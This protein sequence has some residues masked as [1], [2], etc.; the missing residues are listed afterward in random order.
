MVRAKRGA[1]S[2]EFISDLEEQGVKEAS[3]R[4]NLAVCVCVRVRLC[5]CICVC[6]FVRK[7]MSLWYLET[8]FSKLFTISL[9]GGRPIRA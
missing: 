6:S 7:A 1:R 4:R 2:L 8:F 3:Q 5:A 9:F